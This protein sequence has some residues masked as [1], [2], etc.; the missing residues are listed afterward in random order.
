MQRLT[1][2]ATADKNILS[3]TASITS[4]LGKIPLTCR[5]KRQGSNLLILPA[6]KNVK[7]SVYF[8]YVTKHYDMKAYG[9]GGI[10]P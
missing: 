1:Y 7:L 3:G 6:R 5:H 10:A 2:Y 8:Y 9:D 4:T